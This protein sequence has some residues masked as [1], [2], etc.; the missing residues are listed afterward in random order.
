MPNIGWQELLLVLVVALVIFGPKRLPEL[1]RSLGKG[2][3][4][5]KKATNEIQDHFDVDLDDS[6]AKA[7]PQQPVVQAAN[8]VAQAAQPMAQ[9][10]QPMAQPAQPVAQPAQPVAQPAQP[11]AQPAQPVV[12][13][14]AATEVV[15]GAVVSEETDV[16]ASGGAA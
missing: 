10:G 9:P 11:V 6:K 3:R 13:P 7:A 14:A 4:E 5:F 1:G 12:Q 16:H 2:I 8:P 15:T